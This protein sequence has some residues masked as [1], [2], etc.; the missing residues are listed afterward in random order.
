MQNPQLTNGNTFTQRFQ[1]PYG[2]EDWI[3]DRE[4]ILYKLHSLSERLTAHPETYRAI[5]RSLMKYAH[6]LDTLLKG[7]GFFELA[8]S[9]TDVPFCFMKRCDVIR[10]ELVRLSRVLVDEPGQGQE[11]SRTEYVALAVEVLCVQFGRLTLCKRG[12]GDR[13]A[14][15]RDGLVDEAKGEILGR[16]AERQLFFMTLW[17]PIW[18]RVWVCLERA[19]EGCDCYQCL[20]RMDG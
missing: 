12:G 1:N 16:W 20:R 18:R 5:S 13:E 19:F 8:M 9:G 3:A 2:L 14:V 6:K 15:A 10:D 11:P 4:K 17:M 7:G